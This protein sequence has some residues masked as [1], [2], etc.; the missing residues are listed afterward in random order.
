MAAYQGLA[1]LMRNQQHVRCRF[2]PLGMLYGG[3]KL[4]SAAVPR[5]SQTLHPIGLH[6]KRGPTHAAGQ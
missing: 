4:A 2:N 5:A 6:A 3:V 1:S